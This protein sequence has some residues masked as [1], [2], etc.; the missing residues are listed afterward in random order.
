MPLSPL[1]EGDTDTPRLHLGE[2]GAWNDSLLLA[3]P[4]GLPSPSVAPP[5]PAAASSNAD[6]ALE[7]LSTPPD[8]EADSALEECDREKAAPKFACCPIVASLLSLIALLC[9]LSR[10]GLVS[11]AGAPINLRTLELS[12]PDQLK[13]LPN[14]SISTPWE[15]PN[16][17]EDRPKTLTLLLLLL[18]AFLLL[19]PMSLTLSFRRSR[20]TVR[21]NMPARRRLVRLQG[22]PLIRALTSNMC[23]NWN[24]RHVCISSSSIWLST[25]ANRAMLS[26]PVLS[27]YTACTHLWRF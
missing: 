10:V 24:Q 14:S 11:D 6:G 27:I 12:L 13:G 8:I 9:G 17:D 15:S 22:V 7:S 2:L 18:A 26:S 23:T 20:L 3:A 5:P 4:S 25:S 19:P 21:L 1:S 16:E